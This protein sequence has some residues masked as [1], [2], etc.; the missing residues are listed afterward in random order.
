MKSR[1]GQGCGQA[2]AHVSHCRCLWAGCAIT[3]TRVVLSAPPGL[4]EGASPGKDKRQDPA[5]LIRGTP[6]CLAL[7]PTVEGMNLIKRALR[8]HPLRAA[9]PGLPLAPVRPGRVPDR[10]LA[11]QPGPGRA[12]LRP[13]PLGAVGGRHHG[14]PG[15]AGRGA[16][17]AGRR[18]GRPVRPA[19]HHDHVRPGPD[20]AHGPAGRGGRVP[21]AHRARPGDRGRRHGRRC[22][23]HTVRGRG[24]AARRRGRRPARR[25]RGPPPPSPVPASSSAPRSAACCCS[26]GRPRPRSR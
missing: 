24:H 15:R 22:P 16:R 12:G 20:G 13:D 14:R 8:H 10:R 2:I 1:A 21:V 4:A 7:S 3:R 17:P 23:V 6:M 18:A 19:P 5:W 26:S 9:L 25:Q 11:L